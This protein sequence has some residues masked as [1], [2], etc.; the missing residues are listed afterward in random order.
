[1]ARYA[2]FHFSLSTSV[3]GGQWKQGPGSFMGTYIKAE[4]CWACLTLMQEEAERR[5]AN[6]KRSSP[7]PGGPSAKRQ[8]PGHELDVRPTAGLTTR[9][10]G[11][12][13]LSRCIDT[14]CLL[15]LCL[16]ALCWST[17]WEGTLVWVDHHACQNVNQ[18]WF[19]SIPAD[20]SLYPVVYPALLS[21]RVHSFTNLKRTAGTILMSRSK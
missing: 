3:S 21:E 9:S 6:A 11:P 18:S 8:R 13:Y 14:A 1:M 15:A 19:P 7:L 17:K 10:I 4:T 20:C 16:L 2:R 5:L 12:P